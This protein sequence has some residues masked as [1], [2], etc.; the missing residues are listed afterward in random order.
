MTTTANKTYRFTITKTGVIPYLVKALVL[1]AVRE[2]DLIFGPARRKI[3]T[4]IL[5]SDLKP[6]CTILGGT[7]CGEYLARLFCGFLIKQVGEDGFSVKVRGRDN[8][9]PRVYK[10]GSVLIA[11]K[12]S[13]SGEGGVASERGLPWPR[14]QS[15]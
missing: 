1:M 2:A 3:E 9:V 14:L 4:E 10:W 6:I 12:S 8:S 13:E 7:E 15:D 11:G 5:I